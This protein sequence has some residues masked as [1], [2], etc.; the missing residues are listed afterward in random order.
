MHV[1]FCTRIRSGEN[2]R[3][4]L[5]V[6]CHSHLW[7]AVA[8]AVVFVAFIP[9]VIVAVLVVDMIAFIVFGDIHH[10]VFVVSLASYTFEVALHTTPVCVVVI[11]IAIACGFFALP[12]VVASRCV[13][14][15]SLYKCVG[16]CC[17]AIVFV[18][19]V[20][21]VVV[22]VFAIIHW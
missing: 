10:V 18:Y 8:F 17:N 22:L 11:V 16:G 21:V 7:L 19:V 13:R 4:L 14:I 15:H 5:A 1:H 12:A 9:F 3:R 6:G 2:Y 20:V